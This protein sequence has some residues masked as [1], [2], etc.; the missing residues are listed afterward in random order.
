MTSRERSE[1]AWS[2]AAPYAGPLW[3]RA[4]LYSVP[5]VWEDPERSE[6]D[7][8]AVF[9]E[10]LR[11]KGRPTR[12]FAYYA[13]PRV[14][15]GTRCPAMVLIHGGLGSAI[16]RW[17]RL[18]LNRG[19]AAISMDSCGCVSGG[20][21][22]S[23]HARH[24]DG[25]PAGW[26]GFEHTDDPAEDQWTCHAVADA[27]LAHSLIRSLPQVDPDRIG[28]TGISWGGYLA[29]IVAG[30]DPRFRFA[31]PVYG[32]GF[33]GGNSTWPPE[34]RAM[35]GAKA[36]RW[37][38]LW[39]PSLYLP[40]VQ[41]P[42]LWVTGTNDFAYSMDSLQRSYRL[43]GGE[44]TLCVRVNMDHGHKAGEAPREIYAFVEAVLA[45]GTPLARITGARWSGR[46]AW[47]T[48]RSHVAVRAAEF[49]VTRDSGAWQERK[50]ETTQAALD[51]KNGK[52]VAA[53][54]EKAAAFF[55]NLIDERGLVVSSE[56]CESRKDNM[57]D[58]A[59]GG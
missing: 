16:A 44:R 32:C 55:F 31:A 18:W 48:F 21:N 14:A 47:V 40:E 30:V 59:E 9:Y 46:E 5:R 33:L 57:G 22:A 37:L 12:V 24:A 2:S 53:V 23:N 34:L 19:Y 15:P 52:A 29:C 39:D 35:G 28:L 51:I 8:K 41:M 27:I 26:G 58:M 7:V 6:E 1:K 45:D 49:N 43:P 54:P 3:N 50:W 56:H 25:G 36:A 13:V 10:G 20:D 11:W 38:G 42:M 4:A 17:V